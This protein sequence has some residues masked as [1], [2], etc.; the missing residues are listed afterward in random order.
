MALFNFFSSKASS[1]S[2]VSGAHVMVFDIDTLESKNV[3]WSFLE[4]TENPELWIF[5]SNKENEKLKELEQKF[6][7]KVFPLPE[8]TRQ[9]PFWILGIVMFE[10]QNLKENQKVTFV[11]T[12]P[13]YEAI[14]EYLKQKGIPLEFMQ[15]ESKLTK[16]PKVTLPAKN[17]SLS[18]G[19]SSSEKSSNHSRTS[20]NR[21]RR[22]LIIK[23]LNQEELQKIC[24][25]FQE[26]FELEG[27]YEKKA[28]GEIVKIATGKTLHKVFHTRNAKLYV[29]CLY[30]N[31]IIENISEND[32]KLLKYPTPDV[33]P[34]EV[35][36]YRKKFF[37]RR[38]GRRR[39]S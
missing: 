22:E 4:T 13:Y 28:L 30:Q 21:R 32:F 10:L 5:T 19:S 38:R 17:A 8:D 11:A 23:E 14:S 7:V 15:L 34:K 37:N 31:G 9:S 2:P 35:K 18:S 16:L 29:G 25:A 3:D 39:N 1:N 26:H 24:N 6:V 12:L 27:I 20:R 36:V 33:F